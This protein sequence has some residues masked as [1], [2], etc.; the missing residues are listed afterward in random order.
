M[1]R[2]GPRLLIL[3]LLALFTMTAAVVSPGCT[4]DQ[5]QQAENALAQTRATLE[6]E[7]A[8]QAALLAAAAAGS[9]AA[10]KAEANLRTIAGLE[11]R[12]AKAEQTLQAAKNAHGE[13]TPASAA[14]AAG[15]LAPFPWNIAILLGTN[16]AAALAARAP[17]AAAAKR[18]NADAES[19]TDMVLHLDDATPES[20]T[21][22]RDNTTK[23][24]TTGARARLKA[25]ATERA[26]VE[27]AASV[28]V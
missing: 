6:A 21:T 27:A 5:T 26:G 1:R 2:P 16:I 10:L 17:A 14:T 15:A 13:V 19:L 12:L 24:L 28:G 8:N 25:A 20:D 9:E 18:A 7:R 4:S 23:L 22:L 11:Q 3:P